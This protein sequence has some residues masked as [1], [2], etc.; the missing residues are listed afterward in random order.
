MP[1][2]PIPIIS[3]QQGGTSSLVGQNHINQVQTLAPSSTTPVQT[4]G[5]SSTPTIHS[6][7]SPNTPDQ[8]NPIGEG[9]STQSNT[10]GEGE[11]TSSCGQ[12]TLV[13][14]APTGLL[15]RVETQHQVSYI[16]TSIHMGM[17]ENLFLMRKL[18]SCMKGIRKYYRNKHKLNL[19][20]INGKRITKPREGKRREEYMVLDLKQ[21]VTMD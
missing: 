15:K 8:S 9:I 19:I 3:P 4:S 6:E 18:E 13:T 1:S 7:S 17:M 16:C 14:L 10:I 20:L 12:R 11:C 5:H 21:N 2:A